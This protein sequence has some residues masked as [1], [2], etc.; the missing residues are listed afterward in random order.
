MRRPSRPTARW[1]MW[2]MP[3]WCRGRGCRASACAAP[4]RSM[5]IASRSATTCC[6]SR[7]PSCGA[8]WACSCGRL[9]L[10]E[11]FH[12]IEPAFGARVVARAVLLGY[13]LELAQDLALA[14]REL[15]RRLDHHVAEKIAGRLAPHAFHALALEAEGLAALGFRGHANFRGAVQR[16]DGDLAAQRR[17]ADRNRHLPV[18]L[19]LF[20]RQHPL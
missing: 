6:A 20:S 17:P 2:C 3:S 15:H 16:R 12:L 14:L 18:Q 1:R 19:L 13:R 11:L 10:E 5:P 4:P 8:P 7:S 9:A